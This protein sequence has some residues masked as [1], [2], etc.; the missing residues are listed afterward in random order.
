MVFISIPATESYNP[1]R[2]MILAVLQ[3]SF[4][5]F[6]NHSSA[7]NVPNTPAYTAGIIMPLLML[8]TEMDT[9]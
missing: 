7:R 3:C 4:G 5:A 6:K 2:R 8:C 9:K 1:P